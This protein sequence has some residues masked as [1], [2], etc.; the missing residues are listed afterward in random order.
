MRTQFTVGVCLVLGMASQAFA[1]FITPQQAIT[2]QVYTGRPYGYGPQTFGINPAPSSWQGSFGTYGTAPYG[3]YG[4]PMPSPGAIGASPY[5]YGQQRYYS[6]PSYFMPRTATKSPRTLMVY[7][8]PTAP[9]PE[10][11]TRAT[12]LV[13]APADAQVW[14]EG[15][16][17]QQQGTERRF[18]SPPLEAG[19]T[20]S[21][22]VRG[23]WQEN[24]KSVERT[25]TI[26]VE[27]GKEVAVDLR[28]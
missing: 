19:Y 15:K 25:R 6:S 8:L 5:A 3:S 28:K 20:Y 9:R 27:P 7:T 4:T 11:Q 22:Q 1:Q 12:I 14:L 2:G 23:Q 18:V 24:G 26:Q 13:R 16:Q 10:D 21:Y 17:S